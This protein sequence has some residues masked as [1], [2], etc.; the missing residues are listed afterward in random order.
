[1]TTGEAIKMVNEFG[2]THNLPGFLETIET[3]D[4]LIK[5]PDNIRKYMVPDSMVEA[6]NITIGEMVSFCGAAE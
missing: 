3:L 2:Y 4:Y 6:Y 1:M 5:S